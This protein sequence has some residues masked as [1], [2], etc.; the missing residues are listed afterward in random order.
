MRNRQT[1]LVL[2]SY[3]SLLRALALGSLCAVTL[4]T[5]ISLQNRANRAE[6]F[7]REMKQ[8]R[9]VLPETPPTLSQESIDLAMAFYNIRVPAGAS[10]PTLDLH[11]K[12]RGLTLRS[13][14]FGD[15]RVTIG[16]AA[17][18]S[19]ALLGS[20]LAHELEVHCQQNFALI[21]MMDMVGLDGT[22]EA[23]RQAYIHELRNA[24]RFGLK[25]IDRQLIK[26]TMAY[27]YPT[28]QGSRSRTLATRFRQLLAGQITQGAR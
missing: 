14:A 28:Q 11:L 27:F 24:H 5:F 1:F 21:L 2:P 23:E 6:N 19:W 26:D 12:D 18:E 20:T 13:L 25:Q 9:T 16:P 3:R 4:L 15:A 8:V 17:F 22:G 7:W 10:H